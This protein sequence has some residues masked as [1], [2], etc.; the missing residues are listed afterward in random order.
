MHIHKYGYACT[1][2][3]ECKWKSGANFGCW[4]MPSTLSETGSLF[5]LAFT[6]LG[7]LPVNLK[8]FFCLHLPLRFM[9]WAFLAVYKFW[10][11]KLWPS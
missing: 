5:A 11:F 10:G 9:L 2:A 8:G 1:H 6:T 3:T 4:S 7:A